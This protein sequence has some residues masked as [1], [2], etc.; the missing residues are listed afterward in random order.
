M[1]VLERIKCSLIPRCKNG[2][3]SK[4]GRAPY[5]FAVN[6]DICVIREPTI[7][8]L[9]YP[10][11]GLH[12]GRV[13]PSTENHGNLGFGIDVGRSDQSS[14]GIACESNKVHGD[15]LASL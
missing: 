7:F 5:P 1:F 13:A 15:V 4:Y 6:S 11:D 10:L 9:R 12:V 3:V 14:C 8:Q 2:S